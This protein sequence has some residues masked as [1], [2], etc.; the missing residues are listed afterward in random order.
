MSRG[1]DSSS[2]LPAASH[3]V[4]STATASATRR[5]PPTYSAA[6]RHRLVC[7]GPPSPLRSQL[8][9]LYTS[10]MAESQQQQ[11][12]QQQQ[13]PSHTWRE[14]SGVGKQRGRWAP[15]PRKVARLEHFYGLKYPKKGMS[16]KAACLNDLLSKFNTAASEVVR[17]IRIRALFFRCLVF[18]S[19][20]SSSLLAYT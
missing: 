19:S 12:Q 15:V 2:A 5:S 7:T 8:A 6:R 16:L 4:V 3:D 1:H 10:T 18:S 20:S 9:T 17:L 14:D 13:Q 11:E